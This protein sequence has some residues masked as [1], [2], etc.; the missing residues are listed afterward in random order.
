MHRASFIFTATKSKSH[1]IASNPR[2]ARISYI[3]LF[4]S[5][6]C[7][8]AMRGGGG[9]TGMCDVLANVATM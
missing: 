8:Y 7:F 1:E 6:F 5:K 4:N 3:R 2:L 9:E